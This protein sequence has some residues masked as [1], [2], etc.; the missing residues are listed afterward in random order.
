MKYLEKGIIL[1]MPEVLF[2]MQPYVSCSIDKPTL[3]AVFAINKEHIAN[4]A[5]EPDRYS[6]NDPK[7][8]YNQSSYIAP[9]SQIYPPTQNSIIGAS[10]SFKP[11]ESHQNVINPPS[12]NSSRICNINISQASTNPWSQPYQ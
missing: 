6:L 1:P 10:N 2:Y 4:K 12:N 3:D 5:T 11:Q 7:Q 9:S 8:N